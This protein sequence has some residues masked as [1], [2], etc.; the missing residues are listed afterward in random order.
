MK[1]LLISIAAAA[2]LAAC[3]PN[4]PPTSEAP[5]AAPL[6]ATEA[7]PQAAAPAAAS[8]AAPAAAK[9]PEPVQPPAPVEPPEPRFREVVIAAGTP[10]S[11][12]VLSTLASNTSAVEDTVRGALAEP[13]VVGGRTVLPKGA[14]LVGSVIDA[15]ESGRVKG[16]AA[17]AFRFTQV[18]AHGDTYPIQTAQVTLEA[19]QQKSDDVKKGAL[20]G[21]LGAVVGGI[22]GGGTGAAIGAVAGTAGTVLA[23]KGR[24][25]SV[26]PGTV[27]TVL[28][29]EAATVRVPAR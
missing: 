15:K 17:I 9:P 13:V 21:G 4:Q 14:E 18:S 16:R 1:P 3:S 23:T 5:P 27:V 25:V 10:L 12:T 29:Q 2:L 28:M 26:A 20:G 8:Q 19:A 7:A 22:A 11:V 6:A 24:E